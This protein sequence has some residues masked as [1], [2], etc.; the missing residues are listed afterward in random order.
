MCAVPRSEKQVH[1]DQSSKLATLDS[2]QHENI[3]FPITILRKAMPIVDG[4]INRNYC[5]FL[6]YFMHQQ[7]VMRS[8][9]IF[10]CLLLAPN[11]LHLDSNTVSTREAPAA[12]LSSFSKMGIQCVVQFIAIIGRICTASRH[13]QAELWTWK[14]NPKLIRSSTRNCSASISSSV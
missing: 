12:R 4:K 2:V 6:P 10:L 5:I 7:Q 9:F 14:R 3:Y 11:P 8:V 1:G 13:R